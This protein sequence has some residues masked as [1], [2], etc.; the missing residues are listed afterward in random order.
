MRYV[1][2]LGGINVGGHRVKMTGLQAIFEALG[3]QGVATFIASGN[4]LFD[5]DSTDAAE[6][7]AQVEQRLAQ[8]LGYNVPNFLRSLEELQ[9]VATYQP[10]PTLTLDP[11][12][13]LSIL[14]TAGVS[15]WAATPTTG[16]KAICHEASARRRG[17][18][19]Q[20]LATPSWCS[21]P[22]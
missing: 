3:F 5:A 15:R 9:H 6:L 16:P 22:R 17:G 12:D 10:F 2:L 4:V 7:T 11:G 18:R 19:L 21:L 1:A 14:Y 20:G 13:T 8:Q